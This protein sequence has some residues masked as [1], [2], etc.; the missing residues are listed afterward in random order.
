VRWLLLDAQAITDIDVTAVEMLH[1]LHRELKDKGIAMKI[2]HANRPLR[3]LLECTGLEGEIGEES[4]FPSV[5][6]CVEAF[7]KAKF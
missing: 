6:E 3:A 4:F 2:A 7:A 5:H 1:A